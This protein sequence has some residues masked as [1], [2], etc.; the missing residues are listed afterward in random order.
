MECVLWTDGISE[1]PLPPSSGVDAGRPA[2]ADTFYAISYLYYGAL[3]TLTTMLCGVLISY[4]T[5]ECGASIEVSRSSS[6]LHPDSPKGELEG[7]PTAVSWHIPSSR[8]T[9]RPVRP[10]L[11]CRPGN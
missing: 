2:L 6:C 3:G 11:F 4:L 9:L 5:G 8:G 10:V 1:P 7:S